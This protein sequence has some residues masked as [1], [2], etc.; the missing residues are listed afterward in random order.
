[1]ESEITA[2]RER[3]QRTIDVLRN[4]VSESA[5]GAFHPSLGQRPRKRDPEN[6][7]G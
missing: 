5:N 4:P 2:N 6:T 3:I 1:M 7:K